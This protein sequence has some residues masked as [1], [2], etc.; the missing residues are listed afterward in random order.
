MKPDAGG[1]EVAQGTNNN[2]GSCRGW[3]HVC[4]SCQILTYSCVK[5]EEILIYHIQYNNL[6]SFHSVV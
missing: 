6:F 4:V 2:T 1:P 5:N 3:Q